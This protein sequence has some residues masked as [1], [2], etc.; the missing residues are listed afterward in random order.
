MLRKIMKYEFLATG[1]LFLPAYIAVVALALF[2]GI[3]QWAGGDSGLYSAFARADN[4]AIAT[5]SLL[6]IVYFMVVFATAVLT[7]VLIIRRFYTS[8][9]KD[10]G[11]LTNTLPVSVDKLLLGKLLPAICW[12]I[13]SFIV[14]TI[15]VL[16][17][18]AQWIVWQDLLF[19]LDW[20]LMDVLSL[21]SIV[22]SLVT[23]ILAFYSALAIGQLAKRRK[24]LLAIGAYI[25]IVFAVSLISTFLFFNTNTSL[26]DRFIF[27]T[28]QD[29]INTTLI[30][31]GFSLAQAVMHYVI[32]R[33]IL[34]N[35]LNLE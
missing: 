15:S 12:S 3:L 20:E 35:K 18:V 25:G 8:L 19:F 32:A 22:V 2:N 10:E 4:W 21:L 6:M 16:I 26:I 9:F 34:K 5:N 28:D 7:T 13:I 24:I 17:L 27:G 1:R 11:Y 29:I 31:I 33:Y 30:S 14:V 23:G